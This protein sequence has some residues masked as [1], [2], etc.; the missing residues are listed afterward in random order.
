M[1]VAVDT[2]S[3]EAG[4]EVAVQGALQAVRD[5]G[6]KVLLVGQEAILDALV[7]RQSVKEDT[8]R[9]V[10]ARSVIEMTDSPASAVRK[11]PEASVSVAARLVKEGQAIGMFSPGNTGA[12]MAAGLF[13]LGRISGVDRPGIALP[14]PREDGGV[15]LLLDGGANVDCKAAWLVQFAIMGEIYAREILGLTNPRVALLSNGEEA[16]KGNAAVVSA[17][18]RLARLPMNFIGNVEGRD[19]Y[20]GARTADVVVCDGFIGNIVLKATEG[21]AESMFK[22]IRDS[23]AESP[24]ASA[25]ALLLK[26]TFQGVKRRLDYAEYGGAPL[27]GVTHPCI[28]GHGRSNATAFKNAIRVVLDYGRKDV[29]HR[30]A[31]SIRR[32]G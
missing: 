8:V 18:E 1:W 19:I 14:L 6:A 9:I 20:G 26:P 28:I 30:I 2:M 13:F 7:S 32:F 23:I 17:Y 29:N 4:P 12:T 31:D 5:H 11:N 15:S 24:L 25:G 3:G 21:L 22:L 10:S 27:L 16:G